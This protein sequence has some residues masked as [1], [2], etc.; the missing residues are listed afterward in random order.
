MISFYLL[1]EILINAL[2]DLFL[3]WNAKKNYEKT[4]RQK[5]QKISMFPMMIVKVVLL[6]TLK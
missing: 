2:T 5:M 4:D 6:I 3:G 1:I